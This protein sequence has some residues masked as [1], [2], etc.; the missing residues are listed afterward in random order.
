V[1]CSKDGEETGTGEANLFELKRIARQLLSGARLEPD[2]AL[3]HE[4][5]FRA[6][7]MDWQ[8]ETVGRLFEFHPEHCQGRGAVLYVD[9][10]QA[11]RLVPGVEKYTPLRRYPTSS[12]DLSVVVESREYSGVVQDAIRRFGGE[13]LIEV[14]FVRAYEG[15]PLP[16]GQKSLSYRLVVGALD[17]TLSNEELS[18]IRQN[19]ID[20]LRGEGRELRV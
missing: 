20:G 3:P 13:H 19:V 2:A 14:Q 8:G 5:P 6:A 16:E 18:T 15:A 12:F 10:D 4:H 1:C 9:L 17:H 11:L 7:R